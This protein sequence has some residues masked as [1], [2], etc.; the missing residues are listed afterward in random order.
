[1]KEFLGEPAACGIHQGGGYGYTAMCREPHDPYYFDER[2]DLY[3][4]YTACF[5]SP[6][7]LTINDVRLRVKRHAVSRDNTIHNINSAESMAAG[8]QKL[9][10]LTRRIPRSAHTTLYM[11]LFCACCASHLLC[12]FPQRLWAAATVYLVLLRLLIVALYKTVVC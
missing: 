11:T 4:I 9:R 1:M 7:L 5:A 3:N 10:F 2:G 6:P 12:P 8:A